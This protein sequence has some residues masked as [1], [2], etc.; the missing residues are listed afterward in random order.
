MKLSGAVFKIYAK[1][2]FDFLEIDFFTFLFNIEY[3]HIHHF[4]KKDFKPKRLYLT[5]YGVFK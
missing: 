3:L 4:R 2:K 5:R 1:S